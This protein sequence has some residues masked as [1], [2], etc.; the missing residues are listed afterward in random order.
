MFHVNFKN[1]IAGGRFYLCLRMFGMVGVVMFGWS[2][3]CE[4]RVGQGGVFYG[5]TRSKYHCGIYD[6]K[7]VVEKGVRKADGG[8]SVRT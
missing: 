3:G 6:Q 4:F 5:V 7:T 1:C 2:R 8:A